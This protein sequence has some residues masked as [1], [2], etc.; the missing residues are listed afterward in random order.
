M[1]ICTST[2]AKSKSVKSLSLSLRRRTTSLNSHTT[3]GN[4]EEH[5]SRS[6][7]LKELLHHGTGTMEQQCS[8]PQQN[9]TTTKNSITT[10]LPK[11]ASAS[12]ASKITTTSMQLSLQQNAKVIDLT[13]KKRPTLSLENVAT[14]MQD[15]F[16]KKDN[17]SPLKPHTETSVA[18]SPDLFELPEQPTNLHAVTKTTCA[19]QNIDMSSMMQFNQHE[20][21]Q[22]SNKQSQYAI[23]TSLSPRRNVCSYCAKDFA[24]KRSLSHHIAT[25]H[26]YHSVEKGSISCDLCSER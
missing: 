7:T 18:S 2:P 17:K 9:F 10:K 25:V 12:L 22:S 5:H 15:K 20:Q 6:L 8:K 26:P 16:V 23:Q 4:T 11:H 3:A 14:S 24:H 1:P 13:N 21:S 19:A